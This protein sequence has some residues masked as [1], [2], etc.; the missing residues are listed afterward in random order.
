MLNIKEIAKLAGFSISTVSKVMNGKDAGI[1]EETKTRILQVIKEYNY[2]PYPNIKKKETKSFLI[3]LLLKTSSRDSFLLSSILRTAKANGYSLLLT[4][5]SGSLDEEKKTLL[6]LA[7]QNPDGIL[8]QEARKDARLL[9]DQYL[10][11]G[12]PLISLGCQPLDDKGTLTL[13]VDRKMLGYRLTEMAIA[14]HHVSIACLVEGEDKDFIEGYRSCLFDHSIPSSDQYVMDLEG[15]TSFKQILLQKISVVVCGGTHI[16]DTIYHE[17]HAYNIVIPRDLSVL[18]LLDSPDDGFLVPKLSGIV[19]PASAVGEAATQTLINA[20]EHVENPVVDSTDL[21]IVRGKSLEAPSHVVQPRILVIGSSNMDIILHCPD[22]LSPGTTSIVHECSSLP[23]GK[24]ANQA[25][26]VAKLEVPV[27]LL[28]RLG[29]DNEGLTI[30]STLHDSHVEMQHVIMDPRQGTG[31]AYIYV[32][33]N[34]ESTITVYLGANAH[35]CCDDIDAHLDA[36]DNVS[37]CLL[38]TELSEATVIHAISLC[39]K[40]GIRTMVKPASI[41]RC[42][43]ALLKDVDYFIPNELEAKKMSPNC[44]TLEERADLFLQ[45]GAK[46]VIIT[47]GGNGCYFKDTEHS[48]RFNA[49]PFVPVDTT[50]AA[51]AFIA[52]LACCLYWGEDIVRA[53]KLASYAG[54]IS[55]TKEG[56][57]AGLIDYGSLMKAADT[58]DKVI[59]VENLKERKV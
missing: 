18:S 3:A 50:G 45:M 8:W 11:E 49:A 1:S 14:E 20:I 52:A 21:T 26:G 34:G 55:I 35:F 4:Y 51:D 22:T 24:G 28:S 15:E 36:F 59:T 42:S 53:I 2:T 13:G 16:A 47:L 40:R 39:K 27:R 6:S 46:A 23:G 10:G 37:Y 9:C 54:G 7:R 30:F 57:Q 31:K 44:Q 19:R 41:H 12:I 48:L 43:P 32:P 58:I 5:C 38:Q 33:D 29:K 56:S 17:A 25:V